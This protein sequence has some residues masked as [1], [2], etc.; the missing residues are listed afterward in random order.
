M[1]F[2][3]IVSARRFQ[4]QYGG[5]NIKILEMLHS[6]AC[7]KYQTATNLFHCNYASYD[8]VDC[9]TFAMLTIVRLALLS[10]LTLFF[11]IN[12][13]YRRASLLIV[14]TFFSDTWT[15]LTHFALAT[16]YKLL[17]VSSIYGSLFMGKSSIHHAMIFHLD[18]F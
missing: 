8:D 18:A 1:H 16:L 3:K 5:K 2:W 4:L 11:F 13:S 6:I 7:Y 14:V 12:N 10:P 17:Y 9:L 15:L